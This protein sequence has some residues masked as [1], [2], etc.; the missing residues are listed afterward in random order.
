MRFKYVH[1]KR[2]VEPRRQGFDGAARFRRPNQ[3]HRGGGRA[4]YRR[5][6]GRAAVTVGQ[7]L[8]LVDHG[9]L[10]RIARIEHFHRAGSVR[11]VLGHAPLFTRHQADRKRFP[12]RARSLHALVVFQRQQAQWRQIDATVRLHQV[13]HRAVRLARIGR[14][15]QCDE[16]APHAAGRLERGRILGQVDA[17]LGARGVALFLLALEGVNQAL[18]NAV[19]HILGRLGALEF[20]QRGQ[21]RLR[22]KPVIVGF[23]D[24]V[25]HKRRHLAR[26]LGDVGVGRAL[27]NQRCPGVAVKAAP[28][29]RLG[30]YAACRHQPVRYCQFSHL[31][32]TGKTQYHAPFQFGQF[33]T[34]RGQLSTE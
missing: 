23:F 22:I 28:F 25:A 29:A 1:F 6:P 9:H 26:Q 16:F 27:R 14:P 18:L 21:E 12:V 15:Q 31:H 33:N 3:V 13:L 34:A 11:A 19:K 32:G 5:R 24:E 17:F 4:A 8:N 10:D 2:H 7:H 20:G 30:Q